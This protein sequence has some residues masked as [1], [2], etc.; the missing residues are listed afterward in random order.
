[1][2]ILY[3][4]VVDEGDLL[5]SLHFFKDGCLTVVLLSQAISQKNYIRLPVST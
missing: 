3:F 2:L 5:P 1:M 4:V